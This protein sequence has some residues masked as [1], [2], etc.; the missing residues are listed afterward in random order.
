MRHRL[1]GYAPVWVT[2]LLLSGAASAA[3]V[4][5]SAACRERMALPHDAAFDAAIEDISRPDAPANVIGRIHFMPIGFEIPYREMEIQ[6]DHRYSVRAR[7]SAK[8][9]LLY[10]ATQAYPVL[11]EGAGNTV[12]TL[13]LRR[14]SEMTTPDRPLTNAYWK[15]IALRGS[16]VRAAARQREPHLILQRE[17]QRVAGSGGC[18]SFTGSYQLG[19]QNLSFGK[20]ASTMMACADGMEQEAVFFRTLQHV[21]SWKIQID[22][23]ELFDESGAAVARFVAVDLK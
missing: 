15:L 4:K 8:E 20:A 19:G 14:V 3:S 5:G 21:R 13:M 12:D 9:R 10:T 6:P 2:A 23:L 22:T 18:N 11:A 16:P 17:G 1:L 7:I